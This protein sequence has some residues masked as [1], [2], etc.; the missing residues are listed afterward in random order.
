MQPAWSARD[1]APAAVA[2]L[3]IPAATR[4]AQ[5]GIGADRALD[6]IG[7][8]LL[9]VAGVAL[10]WR[11][12]SPLVTLAVTTAATTAFLWLGYAPGPP[13]FAF[14][15]AICSAAVHLPLRTSLPA[16]V[17]AG[18]AVLSHVLDGGAQA[19]GPG[20]AIG[21]A[22]VV[23]G[24][25]IGVAV[26][27]WRDS[28][29]RERDEVL[30]RHLDAERLHLSRDVHDVVGHGLAAINMQARVALR[31]VDRDDARARERIRES[32]EAISASSAA[33]LDE[34]RGVLARIPADGEAPRRPNP[35]LADVHDLAARLERT[36]LRVL[37]SEEGH[38]RSLPAA[39][40]LA[41]YRVAQEALTNALRHGD[42][43]IA[44]DV[45]I[46]YGTDAVTLTVSNGVGRGIHEAADGGG[47]GIPGMRDRVAAAGGTLEIEPGPP[48]F[49]VRATFPTEE[50]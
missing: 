28:R 1:V 39:Q 14:V 7:V 50:T 27:T 41:G 42:G 49:I 40:D 26:R 24:F 23:V 4:A 48:R 33:A 12:R 38:P 21:A 25:T 9:V 19:R 30:R 45:V 10:L 20:A 13:L 18:V 15:V 2:T 46:R 16:A 11:R 44:V 8:G 5:W 47:M 34:L 17:V 32:L 31:S 6:W 35:G 36:G 43:S 3:L 29:D 37:V 22:W